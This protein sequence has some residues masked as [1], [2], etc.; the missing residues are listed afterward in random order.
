MAVTVPSVQ[1][2]IDDALKTIAGAAVMT[3]Y[4]KKNGSDPS[5]WPASTSMG[6]AAKEL[7]SARANVALI[8]A[9][10]PLHADFR[11]TSR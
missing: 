10:A 4:V 5:K 2:Q 1:A 3:T 9:A 7:L 8:V 11:S 6:A